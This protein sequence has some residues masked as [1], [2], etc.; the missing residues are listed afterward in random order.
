MSSPDTHSAIPI[1]C[2]FLIP[3]PQSSYE[4]LTR[5]YPEY[6]Q[7]RI[8]YAQSLYK[9]CMY[10]EAMDVLVKMSGSST[11]HH[12]EIKKLQAAIKHGQGDVASA[13]GMIEECPSDDL[14]TLINTVTTER[15]LL[16]LLG[17]PAKIP[18]PTKQGCLLVSEERYAEAAAKFQEAANK[19]GFN[20]HLSYNLAL[21]R[22]RL[23]QYAQALKH[24]A[25]IIERGIRDHPEL[26]VGMA[27]EGIDVKSVGNTR[28]LHETALVEAFNLKAAIE[29]DLRNCEEEGG[30]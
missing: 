26:S 17:S 29:Y 6:E 5:E 30:V 8:Y 25:D 23:K 1:Q 18:F 14:D 10:D 24:I 7:Y 21:C 4:Q 27:T 16:R 19:S 20:A 13:R 3:Y 15:K 11:E 12:A 28:V 2:P 9:A 22:Y